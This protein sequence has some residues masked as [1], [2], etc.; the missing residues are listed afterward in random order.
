MR[1]AVP[2]LRFRGFPDDWQSKPISS[3]LARQSTPVEVKH[4]GEYREIGV[5]SHGKGIFHKEPVKGAE[6]GNKRVFHVVPGAL[7]INIVFAWE[8]AIALTSEAE[9]GFIA[10]HRFPMFV[11]KEGESY[12]PFLKQ[13]LLTP[14]GKLLLEIASPGGAGRNKT[15]GQ[16]AFLKLKATVPS[17]D[18]QKKIGD[19]VDAVSAKITLLNRKKSA[20]EDYKLG[21]M[22][23]LFSQE[24]RFAREDGSAFPDWRETNFGDLFDW[25]KTNSLSREHLTEANESGVQNIHYGDIHSKFRALF[26]QSTEDVP[27]I[28]ENAPLPRITDEEYLREG[29]I[30]I[31]DA[32]EDY[33]DIG[34]SFEVMEVRERSIIAG[35]HTYIARPNDGAVVPGF[36]GYLLRSEPMRRQITR[37]AQGISVLG[38]SKG[39]LEKLTFWLPHPDEQQK[40]AGALMAIDA[41][42]DAVSSQITH[43]ETFKKGLLQKLFV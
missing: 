27:F 34:K 39:N 22:Q 40:I 36:A 26:H 8:R 3:L 10:S 2:E 16:E 15:L 9:N 19:F 35:L 33:A 23:R 29:D 43:M 30:V 13:F 6:L 14:R 1:R 7:V 31:A 5:R 41:K 18:E 28:T 42:I 37:I 4:E 32:S 38:V 11:E 12:L 20:L 21:L 25:A 17:R 24:V